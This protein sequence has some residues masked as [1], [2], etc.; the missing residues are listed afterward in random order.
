[1]AGYSFMAG[2]GLQADRSSSSAGGGALAGDGALAGSGR[3]A[4]HGL[5]AGS[6]SL[7]GDGILSDIGQIRRDVPIAASMRGATS[8]NSWTHHMLTSVQKTRLRYHHANAHEGMMS[9]TNEA[10]SEL[11]ISRC[12]AAK[13]AITVGSVISMV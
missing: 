10:G 5:L 9:G 11:G 13:G 1:M 8:S 6:G 4:G 12:N 3:A 7:A 2:E